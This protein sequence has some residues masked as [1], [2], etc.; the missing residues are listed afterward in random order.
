MEC[1]PPL[2]CSSYRNNAF[3]SWDC[4]LS[5]PDPFRY[6]LSSLLGY[7]NAIRYYSFWYP[8]LYPSPSLIGFD[9]IQGKQMIYNE[10]VKGA[11]ISIFEN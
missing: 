5:T 6:S 11:M 4:L 2:L 1:K 7:S 3:S 10:S 9:P 8:N